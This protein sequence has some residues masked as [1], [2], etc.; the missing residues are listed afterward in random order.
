MEVVL[1]TECPFLLEVP[2][3]MCKTCS[4]RVRPV[5][6]ITFNRYGTTVVESF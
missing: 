6:I 3:Y 1:N 2:L 5:S 4:H